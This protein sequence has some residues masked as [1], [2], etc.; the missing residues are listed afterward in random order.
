M[1][2]NF[3]A[4]TEAELASGAAHAAAILSPD[5][6]AFGVSPAFLENYASL[7]ARFNESFALAQSPSTRTPVVIQEKNDSKWPLKRASAALATIARSTVSVDDAQLLSLGIAP[8]RAPQR[9]RVPGNPPT[10]EVISVRGR[11]VNIC[12][13][14]P[15]SSQRG[16]PF[17]AFLAQIYSYVGDAPPEDPRQYRHEGPSSR[18]RAQLIFPNT[19]PSGATI[20]LSAQWVSKRGEAGIAGTPISFTLQGGPISAAA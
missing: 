2:R 4:G 9:R 19:I 18:A 3:Y 16:L 20:W 5:P 15:G 11:V 1:S 6:E 7:A 12:L 13:R 10:I 17:G 8:R 14:D